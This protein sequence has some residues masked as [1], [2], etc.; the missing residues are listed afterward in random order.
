MSLFACMNRTEQSNNDTYFSTSVSSEIT[1]FTQKE[2]QENLMA[3]E[4]LR[5]LLLPMTLVACEENDKKYVMQK[6]LHASQ[7]NT[8]HKMQSQKNSVRE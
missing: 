8:A 7:N 5:G 6:L 1:Y 3:L 4:F 2:K